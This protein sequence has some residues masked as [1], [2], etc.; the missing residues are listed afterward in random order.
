MIP[1]TADTNNKISP[2]FAF[3]FTTT[4]ATIARIEKSIADQPKPEI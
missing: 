1:P 4:D 2:S 3:F